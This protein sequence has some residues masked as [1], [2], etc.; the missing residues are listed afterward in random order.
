M[1]L[2]QL[3]DSTN[4][5]IYIC[6]EALY[7]LPVVETTWLKSLEFLINNSILLLKIVLKCCQ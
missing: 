7:S 2:V 4:K 1:A 5:G 6:T 3:V